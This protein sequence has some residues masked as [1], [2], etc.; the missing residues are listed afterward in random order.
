[1]SRQTRPL[2]RR[3]TDA[4]QEAD[5][6]VDV[7]G[8]GQVIGR[9]RAPGSK[10]SAQYQTSHSLKYAVKWPLEPTSRDGTRDLLQ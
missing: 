1:M 6:R 10:S 2:H 7:R 4:L 8:G 5:V 9:T 3:V